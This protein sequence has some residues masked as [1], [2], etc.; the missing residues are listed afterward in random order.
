ML[1]IGYLW[2]VVQVALSDFIGMI[3]RLEWSGLGGDVWSDFYYTGYIITCIDVSILG[4]VIAPS[5]EEANSFP[6]E[7]SS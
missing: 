3:W 4:K 2:I 5:G 1:K 6:V 7:V